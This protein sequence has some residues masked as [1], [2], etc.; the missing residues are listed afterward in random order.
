MRVAIIGPCSADCLE[1][2]FKE[3]L[4]AMGHEAQTFSLDQVVPLIERPFFG[5][6]YEYLAYMREEMVKAH[7]RNLGKRI[8][9]FEPDLVIGTD[10]K[11][12][13]ACVNF[14]KEQRPKLPAVQVNVDQLT[15]LGRQH[16]FLARYD[17]YFTKDRFIHR[18][19]KDKLSLRT[20]YL[21]E[22]FN[23]SY[24][25]VPEY[26]KDEAET[27]TDIDVLTMG[28]LYP[29]RAKFL[30]RLLEA[31]INLTIFGRSFSYF[32][33]EWSSAFRNEFIT[34]ARKSEL[35][36]GAKV[37]LNN[38]HYAEIEAVNCKFFEIMGSAGCQLCDNKPVIPEHARP[39]HEV[40]TF[41]SVDECIDKIR[42]LLERPGERHAM[43]HA[44]RQRAL[45][46][47][48]YE[49]RLREILD[50]IADLL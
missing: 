19:M 18:F 47:H 9:E 38:M 1:F 36:Y 17:A 4:R 35:I 12:H 2:H 34:G 48:T 28:G 25:T 50:K 32:T 37:V 3:T 41:D 14:V 15:T 8:L 40:M 42:Y 24:H 13:S 45:A 43:A 33:G 21:P 44:A 23:P 7:H 30:E 26:S 22:S 16:V 10:R 20:Y 49:H 46:E 27:K 29:Y 31:D 5:K 11:V 39:G 6:A